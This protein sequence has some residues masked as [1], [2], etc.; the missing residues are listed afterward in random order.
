MLGSVYLYQLDLHCRL[1]SMEDSGKWS[2]KG[3]IN[4]RDKFLKKVSNKKPE[5]FWFGVCLAKFDLW[6][7]SLLG[8]V[9]SRIEKE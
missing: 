6:A 1:F 2:I 4:V 5:Y 9:N 8:Q 3:Q 7:L